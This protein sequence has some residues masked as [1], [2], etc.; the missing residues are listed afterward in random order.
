M[1]SVS[2]EEKSRIGITD[3]LWYA[4]NCIKM[5]QRCNLSDHSS[6]RKSQQQIQERLW[7]KHRIIISHVLG[8]EQYVYIDY[9]KNMSVYGFKWRKNK[10][11]FDEELIQDYDEDSSKL[12]LKL[13]NV[14]K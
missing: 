9:A 8:C 4:S 3:R 7:S 1:A 14:E 2:E 5:Y 6:I 10:F 11:M 12:F 13:K